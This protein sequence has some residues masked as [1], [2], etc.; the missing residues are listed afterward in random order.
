MSKR[1]ALRL[2]AMVF[3]LN[4]LQTN[5]PWH[6][7]CSRNTFSTSVSNKVALSIVKDGSYFVKS[8]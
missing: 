7:S 3:S 5:A 1:H 4:R 8:S 2:D 6:M